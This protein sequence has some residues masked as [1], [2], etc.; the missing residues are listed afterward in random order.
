MVPKTTT[1]AT[2]AAVDHDTKIEYTVNNVDWTFSYEETKEPYKDFLFDE[3]YYECKS[4][5]MN[6]EKLEKYFTGEVQ[7]DDDDMFGLEEEWKE[8]PVEPL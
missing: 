4:E 1:E 5:V 8:E 6:G 2:A 7:D 3:D